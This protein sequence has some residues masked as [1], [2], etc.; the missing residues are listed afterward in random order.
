MEPE[1]TQIE[2]GAEAGTTSEAEVE[3]LLA[4]AGRG[5]DQ[6]RDELFTR[7]RARLWRMVA[8]RLDRRAG[9]AG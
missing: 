1:R 2:T 5:D 6:A 4:R 3:A 9:R 7:H 8:V